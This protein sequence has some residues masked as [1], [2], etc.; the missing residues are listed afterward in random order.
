[1]KI[2]SNIYFIDVLL[3][4]ALPKSYT[5]FITEEQYVLLSPGFR[6]AVS[7]GKQKIYTGIVTKVH[8]VAPQTYEPKPIVMILDKSPI[9]TTNQL[10][11]WNW[12]SNYY[13]CTEG[14]VLRASLPSVDEFLVFH[15]Q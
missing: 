11:F 7:F 13:M 15:F 1:M 4:L 8:K 10:D 5:Y 12:I 2:N 14:E 9:I 6:I 3:P